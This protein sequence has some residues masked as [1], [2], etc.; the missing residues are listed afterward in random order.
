MARLK[1]IA[2]VWLLLLGGVAAI[3]GL[4]VAMVGMFSQLDPIVGAWVAVL[5]AS[6]GVAVIIVVDPQ[7]LMDE[8]V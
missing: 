2:A 1:R 7:S 6:L 8:E 3:C 5:I 4:A